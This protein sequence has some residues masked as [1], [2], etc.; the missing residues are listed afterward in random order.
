[1]AALPRRAYL[2]AELADEP[3]GEGGVRIAGVSAGGM[4]ESAGMREGDVLISLGGL[5]LRNPSQLFAA[6]QAAGAADAMTIELAWLRGRSKLAKR[7][8]S[9]RVGVIAQPLETF[10]EGIAATEYGEVAA[11]GAR[12]RTIATRCWTPRAVIA[13]I[14]GTACESIDC[15]AMPDAPLAR[16][17]A[18][19]TRADYDTLRFEKRG[20]GDSEG[21]DC[22]EVDFATELADARAAL[23]QARSMARER[24]IPLVLFGH[25]VG[26]V[27]AALLATEGVQG[28]MTYGTPRMRWS[29]CVR[30]NMGQPAEQLDGRS[31]AYH[32]ELDA[33]DLETTWRAIGDLPVL[34]VHGEYDWVDD[35]AG[36]AALLN[37]VQAIEVKGLDHLFGHH[38]SREE[39]MA[40]YGAGVFDQA[41]VDV[42]VGWIRR[43]IASG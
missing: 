40:N 14:E 43:M 33:I 17:V 42:T 1:M 9:K 2:G 16:L 32:A 39:A 6:L 18:G 34:V 10:L 15:G 37:E 11:S 3:F 35:Q 27:V 38:A 25:G 12:L 26:G 20:V 5:P 29:E 21:G 24:G 28:V 22:S 4:A 13:V 30:T 41:L 23:V 8:L 31:A 19:W 36:I 7:R